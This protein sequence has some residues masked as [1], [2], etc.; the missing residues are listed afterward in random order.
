M[1][2]N[3]NTIAAISIAGDDFDF[4]GL[5]GSGATFGVPASGTSGVIAAA[6]T[7]GAAISNGF[8]MRDTASPVTPEACEDKTPS[9]IRITP[10]ASSCP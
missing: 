6:V 4:D 7:A 9:R 2:N 3:T 10:C 8:A 5:A 1:S